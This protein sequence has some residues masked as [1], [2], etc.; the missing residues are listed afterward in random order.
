[1]GKGGAEVAFAVFKL[2]REHRFP[3]GPRRVRTT[4]IESGYIIREG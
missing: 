3:D 2:A 1:M 4:R